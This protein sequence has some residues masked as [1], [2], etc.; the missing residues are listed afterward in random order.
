M[1]PP[2]YNPE[3]AVLTTNYKR[4]HK[5][6]RQEKSLQIVKVLKKVGVI[7]SSHQIRWL[8][9]ALWELKP[10]GYRLYFGAEVDIMYFLDWR[11]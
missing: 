1:T 5:K 8:E 7:G 10:N 2:V 11:V 9:D 4:W 3:T 6:Q